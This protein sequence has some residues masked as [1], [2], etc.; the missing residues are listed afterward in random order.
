MR[1]SYISTGKFA[2]YTAV[3]SANC[4]KLQNVPSRMENSDFRD[5]REKHFGLVQ[6]AMEGN[7]DLISTCRLLLS[8]PFYL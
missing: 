1:R 8:F 5:F 2:I 3:E 4:N 7:E 6:A